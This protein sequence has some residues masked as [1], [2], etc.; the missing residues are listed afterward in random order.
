[1]CLCVC[2]CVCVLV[3]VF[4]CVCVCVC[5]F[6]RVCVVHYG[7]ALHLLVRCLVKNKLDRP[8]LLLVNVFLNGSCRRDNNAKLNLFAFVFKEKN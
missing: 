2:V 6:V 1:M 7:D 4:V 8:W 3:C 5:V